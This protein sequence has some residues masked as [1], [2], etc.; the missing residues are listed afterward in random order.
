MTNGTITDMRGRELNVAPSP[1]GYELHVG[2]GSSK[3]YLDRA[4]VVEL[5]EIIATSPVLRAE[6]RHV[7]LRTEVS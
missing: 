4:N 5:L 6:M 1:G 7:V 2:S 3:R